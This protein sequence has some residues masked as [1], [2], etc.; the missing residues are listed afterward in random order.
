MIS[1]TGLAMANTIGLRP[2]VWTISFVR[3]P[4]LDTPTNTS[5]PT[6]ASASHPLRISSLVV[7]LSMTL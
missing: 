7:S 1:G 6:T 5:A 4:G 3:T 2:M